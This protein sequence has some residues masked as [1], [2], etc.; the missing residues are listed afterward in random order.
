MSPFLNLFQDLFWE[1]LLY[2]ESHEIST[3][4]KTCSKLNSLCK[5]ENFWKMMVHN[6]ISNKQPK[7]KPIQQF[8]TWL[9]TY[10][11][12]SRKSWI[13]HFKSFSTSHIHLFNHKPDAIRFVWTTY[14]KC[15]QM[16]DGII[17]YS[18]QIDLK[19]MKLDEKYSTEEIKN[20]VVL[21]EQDKEFL[22]TLLL[23]H[24]LVYDT[25][26]QYLK[27]RHMYKSQIFKQLN[28]DLCV[29]GEQISITLTLSQIL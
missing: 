24:K 29:E 22:E 18:N 25:C 1:I 14:L 19:V 5:S 6:N 3:L 2:L 4:A 13:L 8:S 7:F 26:K 12:H 20:I 15:E 16:Y 23:N 28:D 17:S 9:D 27:F 21:T 11:F 10:Q